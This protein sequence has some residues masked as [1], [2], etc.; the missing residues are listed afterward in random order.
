MPI[1]GEIIKAFSAETLVHNSTLNMW[2]T[3]NGVDISGAQGSDIVAALAGTV[4]QTYYDETHGNVV[5]ITH[6]SSRKTLYAGLK[7]VACATGDK[8]NAGDKIGTL[9]TPPFESNDG[10]HLHFEFTEN[11]EFKDPAEYF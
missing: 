2:M 7:D 5:V 1:E 9:G 6:N 10:P 3:H 11:G 4:E 8:V